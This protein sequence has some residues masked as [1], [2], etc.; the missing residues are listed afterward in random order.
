MQLLH[1]HALV[2]KKKHLKLAYADMLAALP[3][4]PR[5]SICNLMP[6]HYCMIHFPE[7]PYILFLCSP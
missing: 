6:A 3:W 1:L 5:R 2:S 4:S 7:H